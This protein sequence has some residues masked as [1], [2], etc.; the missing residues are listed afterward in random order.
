MHLSVWCVDL[1]SLFQHVQRKKKIVGSW[2]VVDSDFYCSLYMNEGDVLSFRQDYRFQLIPTDLDGD[3]GLI[4]KYMVE[5]N[6]ILL[7]SEKYDSNVVGYWE[8]MNFNGDFSIDRLNRNEMILSGVIK[9]T[10]YY[11]YSFHKESLSGTVKFSK[12]K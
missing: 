5:N 10:E 12:L 4:G 2:E 8:I 9:Y 1:Q 11:D 7:E 3:G 6:A